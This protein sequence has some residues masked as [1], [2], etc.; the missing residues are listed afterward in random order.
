MYPYRGPRPPRQVHVECTPSRRHSFRKP[1]FYMR[2]WALILPTPLHSAALRVVVQKPCS[3]YSPARFQQPTCRCVTAR[4]RLSRSDRDPPACL[5]HVTG[6][7]DHSGLYLS[8][9]QG[10]PVESLKILSFGRGRWPNLHPCRGAEPRR[11]T[12]GNCPPSRRNGVSEIICFSFHL[13]AARAAAHTC[14]R[15]SEAMALES[16]V[17]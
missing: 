14:C 12:R 8:A 2:F 10:G 1:I 13:G 6:V 11:H 3:R 7:L 16:L 9:T 5:R 4:R 15:A 17:S